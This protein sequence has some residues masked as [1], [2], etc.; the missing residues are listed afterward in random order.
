MYKILPYSYIKARILGVKIKPSKNPL[1][2]IDVYD[3]NNQYI[4]SIGARNYMDFPTLLK[5]K[6]KETAL[7]HRNNYIKRHHKDIK[8]IGSRGYYA[9]HILW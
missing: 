6:G 4:C 1:K 5:T 9:G 3:W 2:K 7:K 8:K